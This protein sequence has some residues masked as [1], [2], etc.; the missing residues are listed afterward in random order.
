MTTLKRPVDDETVDSEEDE[1][2]MDSPISQ[3]RVAAKKQRKDMCVVATGGGQAKLTDA[4][5]K[6]ATRP[7]PFAFMKRST[8]NL[9]VLH[10]MMPDAVYV[11]TFGTRLDF[12]GSTMG[13]EP[14]R[15]GRALL[16]RAGM[17]TGKS[18]KFREY[19]KRILT[20]MPGAR[21]LLLSANILY[22]SNLAAELKRELK[23]VKVGFYKDTDDAELADC[24]V[25]VCSFESLHRIMGQ[26]FELLLIDEVR[27]IAGLVGGETMR[28]FQN[29]HLLRQLCIQT[30]RVVMCDA[31]LLF[32]MDETEEVPLAMD[33]ISVLLGNARSAVCADLTHPGPDHLQRSVRLF[34]DNKN[35]ERVGKKQWMAE[36][37]AAIDACKKNPEHRFAVCVG[38]TIGKT[39][40]GQLAQICQM[41]EGAG[42]K[43]KPYAGETQQSHKLIDLQDPDT[44]WIEFGAIIATTS[45]SIGVDPKRIRF[46][47]VFI[48]TCRTG[49]I[50]L[51]QFQAAGRFGRSKDAPL[52]NTTIDI[53]LNCAPPAVD[54]A[55]VKTKAQEKVVR[56]TFEDELDQLRKQ[57]DTRNQLHAQVMKQFGHV[58]ARRAEPVTDA[59]LR[60]MAHGKLEKKLKMSCHDELVR[61]IIHHHGWRIENYHA[62]SQTS[63]ADTGTSPALQ[64][65]P[66]DKFY[67][68]LTPKEKFQWAL[69]HI[70][71]Q[72]EEGFWGAGDDEPC[73]G[74]AAR[75]SFRGAVSST[76][77]LS[78]EQFLVKMYW[79]LKPFGRLP[80]LDG[81]GND[82]R[83]VERLLALSENGVPLGLRLN[84]HRRCFSADEQDRRD[85]GRSLQ[86]E[87]PA[88]DPMLH[89]GLGSRMRAADQC[90]NLFGVDTLLDD[91]ALSQRIVDIANRE[92]KGRLEHA[93]KIELMG[94]R[95][96]AAAFCNGEKKLLK[97][98]QCVATGCGM[99]L[100]A[101][102]KKPTTDAERA[103]LGSHIP[104][105][106]LTRRMPDLM[107]HHHVWSERLRNEVPLVAWVEKHAELDAEEQ[108]LALEADLDEACLDEEEEE[109]VD[110]MM[111]GSDTRDQRTEKYDGVEMDKVLQRL[112][113]EE[114]QKGTLTQTEKHWLQWLIVADAAAVPQRK[115]GESPPDVRYLT[116]TYHK[117]REIGRRVASHPSSQ[118]CP[119]G[120]R[121]L[122]QRRFYRD[123][124]VV[125]CHPSLFKQ[126]GRNAPSVD[127]HDLVIV[128]EYV[129]HRD[130]VLDRI[131]EFYGVSRAACKFAVLRML[132]GGTIAAWVSDAKCPRNADREQEDL[133]A[134]VEA[135]RVVREAIFN[136]ARF[137]PIVASLTDRLRIARAA[138]VTRAKAQLAN[139]HSPQDKIEAQKVLSRARARTQSHAI[140]RTIFSLCVF[141]LE[142]S[143]LDVVDES[144]RL[145]GWVV[146]SLQ[147]DGCHVEHRPGFDFDAALRQA[148]ETVERKLGY[149]IQLK[150]KPLF[151]AR[152]EESGE[153]YDVLMDNED[154]E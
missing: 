116:V 121:P 75:D 124:D 82:A 45:L 152:V 137:K 59:M 145:A 96:A 29:V 13:F 12:E 141:E 93:D 5:A 58:S 41:C 109:V 76:M 79:L 150:E 84:A 28:S 32:R 30:P 67:A 110:V 123:G 69:E 88:D 36:I 37:K 131:A 89:V 42:V 147:F 128:D 38:S 142:D 95:T 17:G 98:L 61:R 85:V 99:E 90:A 4:P 151:Q 31:D 8:L 136:M 107:N 26:S 15:H 120:L 104:S 105:I 39:G 60:V 132:N 21:V 27:T 6:A 56:P 63:R 135:A 111:G 46:A 115:E 103:S 9:P 68:L 34:Y 47:R 112:L 57:R 77:Q 119:S 117:K 86:S 40:K 144:L 23:D 74:K 80:R 102:S 134:L 44:A 24:Q 20:E 43:W 53:L 97:I 16:I 18:S 87:G 101:K 122:I 71:E 83:A 14:E 143:I 154:D 127:P 2:Q 35:E 49:C 118:R 66:D 11:P 148:E 10:K 106:T 1:S 114:S 126:V 81:E 146:A 64:T 72:G 50:P 54:E 94:I 92:K 51:T 153:D 70:R 125:N 62:P 129:D 113:M 65:N 48:W 138:A 149:K 19:M 7:D 133:K 130:D 55:L 108:Q 78:R 52:L 73:Y 91:C 3:A 25:V 100:H 22:G 33:F 139:A 140:K